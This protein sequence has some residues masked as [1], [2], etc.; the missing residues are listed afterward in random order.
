MTSDPAAPSGICDELAAVV[1][2]DVAADTH[3]LL[4]A[5]LVSRIVLGIVE[6]LDSASTFGLVLT[7]SASIAGIAVMPMVLSGRPWSNHLHNMPK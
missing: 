4:V 1:G 5:L 6:R 3:G 2:S 7:A